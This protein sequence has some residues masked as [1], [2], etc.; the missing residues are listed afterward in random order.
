M[1]EKVTAV[2][3]L[4][5]LLFVLTAAGHAKQCSRFVTAQMRANALVNVEKYDWAA[6]EQKNAISSAKAWVERSDEELWAMVTSQWLPRALITNEGVFYKGK[7]PGCPNC[8]EAAL[9]YGTHGNQWWTYGD[10][11][12]WKL[13]CRNCGEVFPKNDFGAF[14]ETAL[15]EHGFFRRELGD[16][17]LLFN[18]EHPDP[19]DP[20]H[21]LYVD[22]GYGMV[23]EKGNVHHIIAFRCSLQWGVISRALGALAQAYSLTNDRRYAHKAAVLLDRIADV[24]PDMDYKPLHDMGFQHSQG[25]TGWGRIGG[26]ICETYYGERFCRPYDLI[27]DGI[28]DD[29]ELVAF[30]SRKAKQYRLGDKSTIEAICEHI[31]DDLLL[32]ILKSV[33]DGRV[34]GNVGMDHTCLGYAAVALDRDQVTKQWLDWLFDPAYPG[35]WTD[36]HTSWHKHPVP[37]VLEEGLDRD[38]MG[39]EVGAYGFTWTRK[40][41]ELAEI[42]SAYP[43]YTEHDLA[44]EYPKLRQALLVEPRVNVLDA[45]V[46][47]IGDHG[48]TGKW[49]RTGRGDMYMLGYK[50][51]QDPR[52]AELAWHEHKQHG[53]SLRLW[54]DIYQPDPD[55]PIREAEKI[56]GQ[57]PFRLKCDHLG[58]YGQAV[59]QTEQPADGRALWVSYGYGLGHSHAD[60]LNIDLYAKNVEMLPELGYPEFTGS[61]PK[62]GAWTSNTISHNTLQVNDTHCSGSPGGK[63]GLFAVEPPLRAIA[64]AA[65]ATYPDL[66]TYRRSVALVDVSDTDSYVL[67]VFRARGGKNHRLSYHGAAETATVKGIALVEQGEGTFAGPEVPFAKLDGDD[68]AFY[69]TSGFTYLYDVARSMGPVADSYTVDWKCED[70]R[71]RIKE[72][73]KPHL[74]LHALTPCDEVA[75]CSGDPPQRPGSPRRLRYLIQS[76]LGEDMESQFVTVLEPY[77]ATPFIKQVRR[78]KVEHDADANSV[79]A[80]AIEMLDGTTDILINCEERTAVEV[81]GGIEFDGQFGMIR[82]V[83]GEVKLMRMSNATLLK[84]GEVALKAEVAAYEGTVSKI[85]ASDPQNNLVMLDPPLPDDAE[86]VGQTIHFGNDLP[87]DTSYAIKAVTAEGISTGDITIIQ[88]FRDKADFEAGYKYLVN[89]GDRYCLPCT[90]G[91]DR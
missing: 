25:G 70:L 33:K 64:V 12:D 90:V 19:K 74:R 40:M 87:L 86:F 10:D 30:C 15:D 50:L 23:D 46:P 49:A 84:M 88:G 35:D 73:K 78:L 76:R 13:P 22:D 29:D 1:P 11:A 63:I 45:T 3:A 6:N 71:G 5:L 51:Y 38:G 77:D 59:L 82:L 52:L 41:V 80:V 79:V 7:R 61:W 65:P 66:R 39:G 91:L 68:A 81:E 55:A 31:E 48:A 16:Q 20:L 18:A 67:D 62:R 75:V 44:A 89:V 69:K 28:Q 56:A 21:K 8:G 26:C 2:I 9:K 54:S 72:G 14:Y 47:N 43:D 4:S 27:Y 53:S 57:R 32:E 37:W 34:Q 42:L 60:S 83:N 58:R 17:S 24:Y 85:D 36:Q